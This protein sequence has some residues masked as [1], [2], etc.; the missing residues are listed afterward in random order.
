[1]PETTLVT[2]T[3]FEESKTIYLGSVTDFTIDLSHAQ[4]FVADMTGD[5]ILTV[6]R[7]VNQVDQE[8]TILIRSADPR[9]LTLPALSY[10]SAGPVATIAVL[11]DDVVGVGGFVVS[12]ITTHNGIFWHD[13]SVAAGSIPDTA[14]VSKIYKTNGIPGVVTFYFGAN[15]IIDGDALTLGTRTYTFRAVGPFTATDIDMSGAPPAPWTAAASITAAVATINADALGG[16]NVHDLGGACMGAVLK[17]VVGGN[18]VTSAVTGGGN[19]IV[20]AANTQLSALPAVKQR[21]AGAYLV[22]VND[23]TMLAAAGKVVVASFPSIVNPTFYGV[24]LLSS[25]VFKSVATLGVTAVQI[26]TGFY[27]L[28]LTDPGAVVA[29]GDYILFQMEA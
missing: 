16:F 1:M 9:V 24:Q 14:L 15:D 28:V 13:G 23:I 12:G 27:S 29:N 4:R 10:N 7:P 8:I 26:D 21:S 19:V 5:G 18:P 11:P 17:V 25:G 22:T 6:V 2:Q 3:P 20:S